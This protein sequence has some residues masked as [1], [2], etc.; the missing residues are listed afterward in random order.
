MKTS[1]IE[2]FWAEH[3]QAGKL[4]VLAQEMGKK[5]LSEIEQLT[6]EMLNSQIAFQKTNMP[7]M[8][9]RK[10]RPISSSSYEELHK[11]LNT[12]RMIQKDYPNIL[13]NAPFHLKT[14][15][16]AINLARISFLFDFWISYPEYF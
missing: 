14:K 2:K 13:S 5:L 1:F 11:I 10:Y 6:G 3:T 15:E 16:E 8:I 4:V 7:V 12:V 9:T